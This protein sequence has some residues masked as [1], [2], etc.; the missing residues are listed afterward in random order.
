[1]ESS[2]KKGIN[3]LL[4][5]AERNKLP[6]DYFSFYLNFS[7]EKNFNPNPYELT[8]ISDKCDAENIDF[9]TNFCNQ[10]KCKCIITNDGN[11][12]GVLNTCKLAFNSEEDTI[13][14]F[15]ESDY[16]HKKKFKRSII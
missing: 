10:F 6:H 14:Y 13:N 5:I 1:M 8:V 4:D 11:S 3:R 12:L 9:I 15:I 2:E 16:I 7:T